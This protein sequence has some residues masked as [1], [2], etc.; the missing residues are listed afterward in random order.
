M[1]A[2]VFESGKKHLTLK[3][4]PLPKRLENELLIKVEACGLCKTDLHILDGDLVPPRSPLILGHQIVGTIKETSSHS[5]YQVGDRVGVGWLASTCGNCTYCKKDLENLCESAEFTGFSR[6][7][8]LAEYCTAKE[9]FVY[10]LDK[11]GSA[12]SLAPLLC[13]GIIGYRAHKMIEDAKT[14]GYFGFGGSAHLIIQLA[15]NEGK[16]V[17]VFVNPSRPHK[18][19]AAKELGAVWAGS[20]TDT[21]PEKLDAAILFAPVGALVPKALD[22]IKKG[23]KLIL[24]EIHMSDIPSFPYRLLYDEKSMKSVANAQRKE[25]REFLQ[26]AVQ[27]PIKTY[28]KAYSLEEANEAYTA[29]RNGTILGSAVISFK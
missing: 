20:S 26:R 11:E 4:V 28:T 27:I 24:T 29:M 10:P 7:G 18:A 3:E 17:F 25:G 15:I 2:Q 1:K 21:P 12:L 6:D 23:G 14:I 16:R 9:D 13:P 8:G 22:C 19:D 5:A